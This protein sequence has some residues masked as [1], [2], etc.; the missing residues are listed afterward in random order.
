MLRK[1]Y[2]REKG[3]GLLCLLTNDVWALFPIA[4][5]SMPWDF[6]HIAKTAALAYH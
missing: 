3:V 6:F 2:R 1:L 5:R 4:P